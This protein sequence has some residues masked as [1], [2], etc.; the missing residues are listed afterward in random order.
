MLEATL[1]TMYII[2]FF[3]CCAV[4]QSSEHFQSLTSFMKYIPERYNNVNNH[5][6]PIRTLR[7][8]SLLCVKK[9]IKSAIIIMNIISHIGE[10]VG[11]KSIQSCDV[12]QVS[13]VMAIPMSYCT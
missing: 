11:P 4:D 2:I 12:C 13:L 9:R 1:S 10:N 8:L 3:Y 6:D 5:L 7:P